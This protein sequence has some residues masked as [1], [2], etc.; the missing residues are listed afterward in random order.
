MQ[1]RDVTDANALPLSVQRMSSS[2]ST[3][4]MPRTTT[5]AG[6]VAR[7]L[8]A[9]DGVLD[10]KYFGKPIVESGRYRALSRKGRILMH[11]PQGE[12]PLGG[13]GT[14]C[15]PVRRVVCH[16]HSRSRN[17]K[18]VGRKSSLRQTPCCHCVALLPGHARQQLRG[19]WP[20]PWMQRTGSWTGSI[21]ASPLLNLAGIMPLLHPVR[22]SAGLSGEFVVGLPC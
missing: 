16:G 7:A 10:G 9:A 21:S 13:G 19:L 5:T 1:K 4:P 18:L 6:P 2:C 17:A 8:D 3:A 15:P 11:K 12:G 22:G 14:I 20:G